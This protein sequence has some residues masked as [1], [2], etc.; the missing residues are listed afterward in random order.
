MHKQWV[1]QI[2]MQNI[3]GYSV[4]SDQESSAC[5][6]SCQS[7]MTYYWS[8]TN[9]RRRVHLQSARF[10]GS[11]KL[12]LQ[13]K[14]LGLACRV[15]VRT[16]HCKELSSAEILDSSWNFWSGNTGRRAVEISVETWATTCARSK[17]LQFG[18]LSLLHVK[19]Q[20]HLATEI[21]AVS[22]EPFR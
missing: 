1:G 7:I 18:Q 11:K 9:R 19:A 10:G 4:R 21:P 17:E 15:T 3:S 8:A 20:C 5:A 12:I 16:W 6:T 22:A 14:V 2:R 13:I